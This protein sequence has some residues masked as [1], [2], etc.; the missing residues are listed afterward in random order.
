M[1]RPIRTLAAAAA[2]A[3]IAATPALATE[4]GGSAYANGVETF[5]AGAVP[6][7]GLYGLLYATRYNAD[8]LRGND[9]QDLGVPG[10]KVTA[11]VVAPRLVWVP[12]VKVLGGDLVTSLIVPLV[13]VK[14]SVA[15]NSDSR[16]GLG[17]VVV[18]SGVAWHHSANLHSVAAIDFFLP[19][20]SYDRTRL[21]NAGR[22]YLA[23]EPVYAVSWIDPKG[24]NADIKLG[25]MMNRRNSDTNYKSGDEFHFDYSLGWGLGNGFTVGVGGYFYRQV[26]LDNA[27]GADVAG[28]K[29]RAFA[30]G[31]AFKYDSGQ[32]WLLMAKWQKESGVRNRAQ[33]DAFWLKAVFS[34]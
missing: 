20:G 7:P 26:S 4:G 24:P 30:I 29:G 23:W 2:A 1:T 22:N 27:N 8:S 12:G 18:G 10:F 33:G 14:V 16:T 28:S 3:C 19:T 9:G 32:G 11:N 34:L 25:Y 5:M 15:G 17:D 13:D 21:A 31:P 6:P